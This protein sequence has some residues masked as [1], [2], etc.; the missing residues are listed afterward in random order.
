MSN[1]DKK[2]VRKISSHKHYDVW[3]E[4]WLTHWE[5]RPVGDTMDIMA[6]RN[7]V[8]DYIGEKRFAESLA[9]HDIAPEMV[10][11]D[12][13]VCCIGW[14]E[15]ERK[16]FGWSHRAIVGFGVGDMIFEEGFGDGQT[17]FIKHGRVEI[18]SRADARKAAIKFAEH[19]G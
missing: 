3:E 10:N 17:P 19:V 7:K 11:E 6:A 5:D 18:K 2:Q 13:D 8:G 16:Y 14:S 15:R 1:D 4:K 9:K 12:H